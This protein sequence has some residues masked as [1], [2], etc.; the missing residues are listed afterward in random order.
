MTV[1]RLHGSQCLEARRTTD[2]ETSGTPCNA[3][4]TSTSRRMQDG[5]NQAH[6]SV[7]VV[8]RT[9]PMSA[10]AVVPCLRRVSC[11]GRRPK[12][13]SGS[14]PGLFRRPEAGTTPRFISEL[15]VPAVRGHFFRG[16][17]CLTLIICWRPILPQ[18]PSRLCNHRLRPLTPMRLFATHPRG[19]GCWL[20]Y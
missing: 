4:R 9:E 19:R 12:T 2:A 13:T 15:S 7:A 3:I 1:R 10:G 6:S 5:T 17:N 20:S 16:W 11:R 14:S 18:L 8:P